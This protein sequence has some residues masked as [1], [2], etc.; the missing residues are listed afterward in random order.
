[1]KLFK[2]FNYNI[3]VITLD[4]KSKRFTTF[5]KNYNKV[6]NWFIDYKIFNGINGH[7]I[8]IPEWF[9]KYNTYTKIYTDVT[10]SGSYGCYMSHVTILTNFMNNNTLDFIIIFEDDAEFI[11]SFKEDFINFYNNIPKNWDACYLGYTLNSDPFCINKYCNKVGFNGVNTTVA[12]MINKKGA[13]KFLKQLSINRLRKNFTSNEPIDC[14]YS[15]FIY[16]MNVYIPIQP[17][18]FPGKFSIISSIKK[19]I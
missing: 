16:N 11:S 12:Y 8:I 2:N 17:L 1:M 4:S 19:L 14:Q 15:R 13:S 3:Y 10:M 5:I 18:V 7:N 9:K 6:K